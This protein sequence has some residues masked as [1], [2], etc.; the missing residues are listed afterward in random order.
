[1]K[2]WII[3]DPHFDHKNL[4]EWSGRKKGWENTFF[5]NLSEIVTKEDVLICLGDVSF[6]N[7]G[8]W[9]TQLT[10]FAGTNILIVGNH[11]KNTYTWYSKYWDVVCEQMNIKRNGTEIIFSHKPVQIF[12]YQCNIHGHFHNK[13]IEECFKF[14]PELS[15]IYTDR[16]ISIKL[17]EHY[18]AY[19]LDKLIRKHQNLLRN[20]HKE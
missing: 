20:K 9:H 2:Y 14:E 12:P 11:D 18:S 6:D 3:T 15:G 7:H 17:E 13:P 1:M 8:H 19:R 5:K 16:H 10:H 4:E